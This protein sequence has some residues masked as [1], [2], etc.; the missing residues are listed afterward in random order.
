M[1]AQVLA[2]TPRYKNWKQYALTVGTSEVVLT[3]ISKTD[4]SGVIAPEAIFVQ[5]LASNT[6]K[7]VIGKTGVASNGSA[8]GF[9]LAAGANLTLPVNKLSEIFAIATASSQTLLVTYL[10]NQI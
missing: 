1:S 6:G 7:I 9:E 2:A 10:S 5:A 3:A 8:G 4:A